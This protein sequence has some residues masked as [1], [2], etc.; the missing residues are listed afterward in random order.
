M[1][2]QALPLEPIGP[3]QLK[4]HNIHFA[5]LKIICYNLKDCLKWKKCMMKI[6]NAL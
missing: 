3:L 6:Q 2:V 1:V 5:F 4:Y